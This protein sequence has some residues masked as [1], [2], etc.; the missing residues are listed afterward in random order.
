MTRLSNQNIILFFLLLVSVI[1]FLCTKT[2]DEI[3]YFIFIYNFLVFGGLGFFIISKAKKFT[4]KIKS[5]F[6]LEIL[7]WIFYYIIFYLPYTQIFI[8]GNIQESTFISRQFVEQSNR[9]I[10]AST[11]GFIS[12]VIGRYAPLRTR[13]HKIQYIKEELNISKILLLL[14]TIAS[15][16]FGI[17]FLPQ[18]IIMITSSY[19]GSE[20]TDIGNTI[21]YFFLQFFL[22]VMIINTLFIYIRLKKAT[23]LNY[24]SCIIFIFFLIL[25]LLTGDRSGFI[26]LLTVPFFIITHYIYK[27]KLKYIIIGAILIFAIYDFIETFRMMDHFTIEDYYALSEERN[28]KHENDSSFNNTT[29]LTRASFYYIDKL[30]ND[31]SYGYF[32]LIAFLRVIPFGISTFFPNEQHYGT[33]TILTEVCHSDFSLGSSII[34][35][36]YIEFGIIGIILYLFL[37]GYLV[38][39]CSK[40]ILE[41]KLGLMELSIYAIL[42]STVIVIPRYSTAAILREIIWMLILLKSTKFLYKNA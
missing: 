1:I 25:I 32:L 39:Y 22:S 17:L 7:F 14:S 28:E 38:N 9:A 12:F 42:L 33:S 24:F 31:Y 29:T 27:I 26:K 8:D 40:K 13:H 16:I 35:E 10:T 18:A 3:S 4:L 34:A 37:I 20:F 19:I 15:L 21:S 6:Q 11:I 5:Y 41:N 2:E 23:F 30:N 36:A